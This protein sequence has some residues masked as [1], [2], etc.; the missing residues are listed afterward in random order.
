SRFY[1]LKNELVSLNLAL[2]NFSLDFLMKQGF[3]P[4]WTPFM[5]QKPAMSGA[6]ELS[7]FENQLYKIEKEDLFL[8]AT[9]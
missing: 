7:D 1:Y 8:I 6:A 4:V 2:I 5:L 3:V 9:A